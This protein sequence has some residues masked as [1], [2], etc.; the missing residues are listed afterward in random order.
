M[1]ARLSTFEG[2]PE[3]VEEFR[4]AAVEQVLPMLRRLDGFHGASVLADRRSGKVLAVTL[5]E[6]EDAMDATDEAAYWFRIFVSDAAGERLTGVERFE[7]LSM[8]VEEA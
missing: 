3:R 8:E 7:V 1:F 5:W 2:D 6:S 4:R